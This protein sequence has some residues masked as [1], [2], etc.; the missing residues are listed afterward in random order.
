[1]CCQICS[2]AYQFTKQLL[3]QHFY[4]YC[5]HSYPTIHTGKTAP[6]PLHHLYQPAT[7]VMQQIVLQAA[8]KCPLQSSFVEA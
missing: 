8:V 7:Y 4:H 6:Q 3:G 5:V 2:Q 1:M